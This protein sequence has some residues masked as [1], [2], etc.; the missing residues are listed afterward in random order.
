MADL[1]RGLKYGAT[2]AAAGGA[3]GGPAGAVI[4]G[5]LS[6]LYGLFGGDSGEGRAREESAAAAA[7]QM[8]RMKTGAEAYAVYRPEAEQARMNDLGNQLS[9][10]Q[11]ANNAL[12]HMYGG[13][14]APAMITPQLM[15][16]PMGPSM[17]P[18]PRG[19]RG[20][21]FGGVFDSP[22]VYAWGAGGGEAPMQ[23]AASRASAEAA[24]RMNPAVAGQGEGSR[25]AA[26]AAS[27]ASAEAANRPRGGPQPIP[28]TPATMSAA[29]AAERAR[30]AGRRT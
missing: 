2:G 16:T 12:T 21:N 24:M 4:V 17:I 9:A 14:N 18:G 3:A 7:E 11:G 13:Q 15:Q 1:G 6:G 23:A 29:I 10:Y 28:A 5:G 22:E 25:A 30:A 26:N 27:L 20:G 19:G 8:A